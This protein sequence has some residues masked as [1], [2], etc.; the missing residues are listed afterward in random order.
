MVQQIKN[1]ITKFMWK[2]FKRKYFYNEFCECYM[3]N[4][5]FRKEL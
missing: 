4:K 5:D 2:Y 1:L 3:C